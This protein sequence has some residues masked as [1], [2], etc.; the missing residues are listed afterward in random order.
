MPAPS[1]DTRRR[2]IATQVNS[3]R[4]GPQRRYPAKLRAQ[5]AE[6][7]HARLAAGAKRSHVVAELGVSSP[8]LVRLLAQQRP[9]FKQVRLSAEPQPVQPRSGALVVRAPG[10]LVIE[11][12]DVASLAQLLRAAP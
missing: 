11:G 6:Y 9:A 7:A 8:T 5:I 4:G 2:A 1:L 12:L 3:L 10:G